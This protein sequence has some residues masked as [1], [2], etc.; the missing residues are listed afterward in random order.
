MVADPLTPPRRADLRP[1][2]APPAG[3]RSVYARVRA[4]S[5]DDLARSLARLEPVV[6]RPGLR[7]ALVQVEWGPLLGDP[8]APA[9]FRSFLAR[10]PDVLTGWVPVC[11]PQGPGHETLGRFATPPDCG[12]CVLYQGRQCQG[13]GDEAVPFAGATAGPAMRPVEGDPRAFPREA[14]FGPRPVC[15]WRPTH[16]QITTIAAAVRAAGG[17]LWDLGAG[18]GFVSALLAAEGG[19]DVTAVDQLDVYPAPP[20][21]RRFVGDVRA[22]PGPP[23]GAVLISWPPGGDGFRDVVRRLRPDVLVL[24]YDA[25]ALCGRRRAH[26]EAWVL[27][28]AIHWF[29]APHDDFAP[30]PGL[31]RRQRWPVA[32]LHDRDGPP[33]PMSGVLELRTRR[34]V[35]AQSDTPFRY[36]WEG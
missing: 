4:A 10:R 30:W 3:V 13:L 6:E 15:H 31:P 36:P 1:V 18:N 12:A 32:S 25:D 27:P 7:R 17:T 21:V 16:A 24:A 29:A 2:S 22:V 9:V 28:A 19:L 8:E 5:A 33:A 35:K 14:F 23:P 26:A 20:G 34:L 11:H